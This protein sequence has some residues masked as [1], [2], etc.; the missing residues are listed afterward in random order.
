MTSDRLYPSRPFLA[1]S[2][3]VFRTAKRFS[4]LAE[5]RPGRTFLAPW[6]Q[7]ETGETSEQAALGNSRRKSGLARG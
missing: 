5:S 1:A 6:R 2:V 7:V 4:P 3:A